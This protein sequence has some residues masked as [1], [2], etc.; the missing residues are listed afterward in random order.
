MLDVSA[1]IV[2]FTGRTGNKIEPVAPSRG[3]VE[4]TSQRHETWG[5]NEEI[6]LDS[7]D[8]LPPLKDL[9]ATQARQA[10]LAG[11]TTS[12]PNQ[13]FP[14]NSVFVQQRRESNP[15]KAES[16]LTSKGNEGEVLGDYFTFSA[17]IVMENVE[18][19][20]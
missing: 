15:L 13:A 14:G 5:A 18:I 4:T 7:D 11:Q 17:D 12:E 20:C 19:V 1:G 6:R 3:R 10:L 16:D 8:D 2:N 9:F